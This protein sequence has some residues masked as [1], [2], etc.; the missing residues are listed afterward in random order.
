VSGGNR[1]HASPD[2]H[3]P[4]ANDQ[5]DVG[6]GERRISP[7]GD[8]LEIVD[9][10]ERRRFEVRV[11]SRVVGHTRYARSGQGITLVHTEVDP[12]LEGKGIASR[13]AAAVLGDVIGQDLAVVVRCPF[14]AAYVRRHAA[15]YPTVELRD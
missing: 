5:N 10:P 6:G 4:M 3:H 9:V 2:Y 13:L 15:E 11:G 12:D 7:A 14:V 1:R 8:E